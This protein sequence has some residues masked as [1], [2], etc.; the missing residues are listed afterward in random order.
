VSIDKAPSRATTLIKEG[1]I[2]L[3]TTRPYLGAFTIVPQK[4]DGYVCSSGFSLS[5]NTKRKDIDKEFLLMFL[6]SAAGLRQ[7]ERR[8]TGGLYPAITQGELEKI[9]VPLPPLELQQELVKNAKN[10]LLTISNSS[11]KIAQVSQKSEAELEAL[12]L[13]NNEVMKV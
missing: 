11:E 9:L 1:D 6:K 8:M 12:I 5:D 4:Y 10:G 7:M 3:S 2:L 13:G